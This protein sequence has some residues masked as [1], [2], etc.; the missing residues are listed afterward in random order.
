M[1]K[2]KVTIC[3]PV[4]LKD[5]L[6]QEADR[7]GCNLGELI[8]DLLSKSSNFGNRKPDSTPRKQGGR[9]KVTVD[10]TKDLDLMDRDELKEYARVKGIRL[11][12]VVP[13]KMRKRIREVE[14]ARARRGDAFRDL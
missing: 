1:E 8:V 9:R 14:D 12:T 6:Q 10:M 2:E 4:G 13:E 3:I 5:S 7:R 11:F